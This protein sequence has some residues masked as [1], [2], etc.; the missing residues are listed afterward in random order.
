L[1]SAEAGAR[2]LERATE[3]AAIEG[4]IIPFLARAGNSARIGAQTGAVS[5]A[6]NAEGTLADRVEGSGTGAVLGGILGAAASPIVD[7]LS[8]GV[9]WVADQTVNRLPFRQP[10][11]A[12]RKLAEALHNDGLTPDQA[13]AAAKALGDTGALI[14]VGPNTQSLG[15][16]VTT[17][18]GEGKTIAGGFLTAR[19]EGTRDANNVLTGGQAARVEKGI[20]DLVPENFTAT[21]TALEESKPSDALYKSAYSA[22]QQMES[23]ELDAIL[24]TPAGSDALKRAAKTM[25]NDRSLVSAI[26]PELTAALKEAV[27]LGKADAVPGGVG[28]GLKM[29]TLD[30]VKRELGDMEQSAMNA[31]EKNKARV[32]GDLRR[33]LTKEMDALDVTAKAGPKAL[34]AD[35][36]DYA[37]ARKLS[38]DKFGSQDALESGSNFMQRGEFRNPDEL[39]AAL[40]EMSAEEKHLF[41]VGAMQALK[42]KI[43]DLTTR[44]DVTKRLLNIPSLEAKTRAV[45]GDDAMF[46]KYI[47]MLQGEARQANTYGKIMHG[48]R[49]AEVGAEQSHTAQDTGRIIQGLQRM[50]S[51]NPV[52]WV[53]GGINVL[54]G[55]KDRLALP[56]P[57]SRELA[58]LLTQNDATAL[59]AQ[60]RATQLSAARRAALAKALATGS[61]I[62]AGEMQQ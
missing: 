61:G 19:Q 16:A 21:K 35:G 29:R 18:P 53:M 48:S 52:D 14:D 28:R 58:K 47:D 20:N 36:G 7:S 38:A 42:E 45:F 9:K 46:K 49:T 26:D 62:G 2:A 33:S 57:I 22:N 24:R 6:L 13:T 51:L 60:Y 32:L 4:A 50:A 30:Y 40:A 11:A 1:P 12:A 41:R 23:K 55:A 31:G 34:K 37:K 5:G 15:R 8:S 39:N 59:K 54:G 3:R 43:G 56:Q 17:V 27:E 25:Q 10:T 44:A